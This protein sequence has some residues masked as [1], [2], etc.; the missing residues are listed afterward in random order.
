MNEKKYLQIFKN[1][2]IDCVV[3]PNRIGSSLGVS[4]VRSKKELEK[5]LE[6]A[7]A[8]DTE[9]MIEPHLKGR[10]FTIP[11]LGNKKLQVL[12]VIEIIPK[13]SEFFDFESKYDPKATDEIVPAQISKSLEKNLQDIAAEVHRL[14]GCRGVS[15][16]DFIVTKDGKIYFLEINTIPGMT[17][18]SLV[19][20]SSKVA[21][22][23]YSQLLDKLIKLALDK[24]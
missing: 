20:K 1:I 21:G 14:L 17:A 9:V 19:P 2:G 3:K 23:S 8:H 13:T 5:A 15:R 6:N 10:E 12:P 7:L 16:S 24:E 11:V 18:N 22:I 4:I